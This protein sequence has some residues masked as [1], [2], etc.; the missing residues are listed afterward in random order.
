MHKADIRDLDPTRAP[1]VFDIDVLRIAKVYAE[2]LLL[3]ATKKNLVDDFQEAFDTLVGNPLRRSDEQTDPAALMASTMIPRQKR[4]EIIRK[5]FDGKVDVLFVNFIM[6]LN[7][8]DR[9]SILRPVAAMYRQLRDEYHKRVRVQVHTAVPLQ[10]AQKKQLSEM[11]RTRFAREPV[12]VEYVEPDL[13]GGLRVQVGDQVID[14]SVKARLESIK[15]Q[16]I[17]RSNHEIQRRRS[18]VGPQG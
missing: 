7:D 10:E 8:H 15:N 4:N 17:E 5:L 13:L 14:L 18:S 3:A 2:A 12:L 1:S 6:V 11:A 9:L 16:L